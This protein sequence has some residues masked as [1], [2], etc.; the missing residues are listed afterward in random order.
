MEA[1]PIHMQTAIIAAS[2][3]QKKPDPGST[4]DEDNF[5]NLVNSVNC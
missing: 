1:V 3:F 2:H 4:A 5:V